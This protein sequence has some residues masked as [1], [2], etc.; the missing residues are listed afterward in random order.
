MKKSEL[1][2]YIRENTGFFVSVDDESASYYFDYLNKLRDS[3][4][5]NM[6]T[7]PL[8]DFVYG[9]DKQTADKEIVYF[10]ILIFRKCK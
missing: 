2:K 4:V 1:K 5:T 3:G 9:L 8:E 10:R 7:V 6:F